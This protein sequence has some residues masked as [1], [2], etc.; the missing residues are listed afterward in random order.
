[1][2]REEARAYLARWRLVNA[3][4]REELRAAAPE[5]KLRQLAALMESVDAL[6]WRDVLAQGE[7]EVRERWGQLRKAYGV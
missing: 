7:D 4:E 1:M 6:G 2:T 3:R 5:A